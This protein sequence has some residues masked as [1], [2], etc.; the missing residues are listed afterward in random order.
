[1][2]KNLMGMLLVVAACSSWLATSALA[3]GQAASWSV[4]STP[5][6]IKAGENTAKLLINVTNSGLTTSDGSDIKIV[7]ELPAGLKVGPGGA[8]GESHDLSKEVECGNVGQIVTC[9]VA[10]VMPVGATDSMKIPVEVTSEGSGEISND[11]A[12]SG[13][14][15]PGY[16]TASTIDLG[17]TQGNFGVQNLEFAMVGEGNEFSTQAGSHPYQLT[18]ALTLNN[19]YVAGSF[20]TPLADEPPKDVVMNYP[21]GLDI[22]PTATPTRCTEDEFEHAQ[23]PDSSA[24]GYVVTV[25]GGTGNRYTPLYNMVAPVDAPAQ[26][27]FDPSGELGI[28]EHAVPS[29]RTGDDY[30][31]SATVSGITDGFAFYA[32]KVI[33]WGNPSDP[34]HDALRGKCLNVEFGPSGALCP[35]ERLN[36]PAI[37]LPTSCAGPLV[38]SVSVDSWLHPGVFKSKSATLPAIAGCEKLDFSPSVTLQPESKA[39]DAPTGVNV[40]LKVSQEESVTGLGEANLKDASFTLPP[41]LTVNPSSVDGLGACSEAQIGLKDDEEQS[42]PEASK[43]GLVEVRTPLLEEPLR[44]AVYLAQQ[45]N[46][47]GNGS[48]PFSSLLAVYIS[49]NVHGVIVKLAGEIATNPV[50]G[51]L[52]ATFDNNPQLPFSDFK[53]DFFGGD[54]GPLVTPSACGTYTTTTHLSAWSGA[55]ATPSDSFQITSGC[56]R[57]FSPSFV[58]GTTNTQAGAYSPL[59]VTLSRTDQD[60]YLQGISVKTPPGLLGML[61][62]VALC[63]EPQ[64]S[65]GT[66]SAASLIGHA[67]VGVGPGN[68]P[69]YTSGGQVFLTGPYKGAPFGLSITVPAVAGPFNLGTVVVRATIS[70]DPHTAALTVTS[71]P[72]PTI[73]QGVVLQVKTVNVTID[74][75]KFMFNPTDCGKLQITGTMSSEQ[76]ASATDVS[77]FEVANCAALAFKPK[78]AVSTSGKTTRAD[79]AS[80][81]V[82]LTYPSGVSSANIHSVKVD[83]P[84]QLPSQ[85]KTL[86]K[87]CPVA[88]FNANP[89]ACPKESIVGHATALTPVLPVQLTGPAY[90]VSH[91]G[92]EFP[93]LIVVLQG[94]GVTVDLVGDTFINGKTNVTSSTFKEIPDVPVTSFE[95]ALPQGKYAALAATANLCKTKLAMPTEFIAQNGAKI[96][97]STP[98]SVTGCSTGISIV[99]HKIKG[100]TLTVSVSVPA[101]GKVTASGKDLSRSSKS[102]EGRETLTF[103]LTQKKPGKLSTKLKIAFKPSKGSKQAKSLSVKFKK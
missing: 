50:T 58:S 8:S 87:A 25:L 55:V 21:A 10:E 88:T 61:S 13:G 63:P 68:D 22:N 67:T 7:D 11:I 37:S 42:C 100:R 56:A 16:A 48:N 89:A 78:F 76:G 20:Q 95:L 27:A 96:N 36:R 33:L 43:I 14:G 103:K 31:I 91:A 19:H 73:L 32:S 77:Q 83:L 64:A 82:K 85:L 49:V 71:D 51:Q 79:G 6:S 5:S 28:V 17:T 74:R 24:V 38:G 97:E 81:T 92:E 86:Q 29:V 26:F 65:Q 52:T 12:V 102:A 101:A 1:M 75:E 66:C 80:L 72:F 34:S 84:K 62:S 39:T 30:G 23:C 2:R 46:L 45:G 69:F 99:S 4:I 60:Q 70:V 41:G 98:I 18:T 3:A 59:S 57:G 53:L 9:T 40:D 90:F 54:R 93:Q 44:G 15:L 35:V 47:L 94:Y